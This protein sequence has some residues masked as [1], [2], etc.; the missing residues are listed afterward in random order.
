MTVD[1]VRDLARYENLELARDPDEKGTGFLHVRSYRD[2]SNATRFM[3]AIPN[4]DGGEEW[5]RQGFET[6]EEAALHVAWYQDGRPGEPTPLTPAQKA[7]ADAEN[8][9]LLLSR[10]KKNPT[11]YKYV[12]CSGKKFRAKPKD[13]DLG[14]WETA[15][16]AALA[17]ARH[18]GFVRLWKMRV[19][20]TLHERPES[21][22]PPPKPPSPPCP[23]W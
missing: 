22:P 16:Q 8:E 10:S 6:A 4:G 5:W 18:F 7:L 15:E 14:R 2:S 11:G 13:M 20:E 23:L 17:V 1:E 9:K 3:F 19:A 21:M 12:F